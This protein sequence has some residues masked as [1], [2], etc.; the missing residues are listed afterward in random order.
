VVLK[1]R[2]HTAQLAIST[3]NVVWAEEKIAHIESLSA[4]T[5]FAAP[6]PWPLSPRERGTCKAL[7]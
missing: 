3:T 7:G 1:A 4:I 6:H 5:T 2:Y